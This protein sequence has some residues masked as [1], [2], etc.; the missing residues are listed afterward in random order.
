MTKFLV[1]L[2]DTAQ[3]Y[4][5]L[6]A[7][8]ATAKAEKIENGNKIQM[9]VCILQ[10]LQENLPLDYYLEKLEH[11]TQ[12]M[13]ELVRQT[14]IQEKMPEVILEVLQGMEPEATQLVAKRATEWEAS[15]SL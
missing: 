15:Q 14:L 8:I 13:L 4:Q 9:R 6:Q 1:V 11:S 7:A 3:A 10:L 2:E 12:R 5:N